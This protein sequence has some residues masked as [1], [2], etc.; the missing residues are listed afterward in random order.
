MDFGNHELS[1]CRLVRLVALNPRHLTCNPT[2]MRAGCAI[3]YRED[4]QQRQMIEKLQIEIYLPLVRSR[5]GIDPPSTILRNE[6]KIIGS[7]H[8]IFSR[9]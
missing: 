9:R 4:L 5:I 7:S 3:L 6:A 1:L 8:N 2:L